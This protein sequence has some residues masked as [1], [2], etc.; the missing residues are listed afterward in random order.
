MTAMRQWSMGKEL[1]RKQ[2]AK[3]TNKTALLPT[4]T[5]LPTPAY[6]NT[7][8]IPPTPT[9]TNTHYNTTKHPLRHVPTPR[10]TPSQH[11]AQ[12]PQERCTNTHF[13]TLPT[14]TDIH[15]ATNTGYQHPPPPPPQQQYNLYQC[16]W[17]HCLCFS[18]LLV[19]FW[20][21]EWQAVLLKMV[22]PFF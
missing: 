6:T 22:C 12:H 9:Y 14:P 17:E 4:T 5:L 15:N 16:L 2:I 18:S 11:P 7:R 13:R 1:T 19:S 10:T 20:N 8:T 21:C 3:Q